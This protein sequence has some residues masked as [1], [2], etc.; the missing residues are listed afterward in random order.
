M[1]PS[2]H[3]RTLF[4]TVSYTGHS[5]D[6]STRSVASKCLNPTPDRLG[7]KGLKHPFGA[8][9]EFDP[10]LTMSQSHVIPS[11]LIA[12]VPLAS[13]L[14]PRSTLEGMCIE[15]PKLSQLIY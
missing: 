2:N 6:Y 4:L 8:Y 5:F 13:H 15:T 1:Y 11:S 14:S 10:L 12:K 7:Y 3:I 9:R